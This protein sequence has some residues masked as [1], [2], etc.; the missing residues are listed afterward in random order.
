[1][2]CRW[3]AG[4]TVRPRQGRPYMAFAP[5]TE[6]SASAYEELIEAELRAAE[7]MSLRRP[8]PTRLQSRP[9]WLDAVIATLNWAW[10]HSG[11]PPM[12]FEQPTAAL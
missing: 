7:T 9:G 10:H 1:M 4:A 2:T 11:Q 12:P 8:M 3:L 5:V 6:R